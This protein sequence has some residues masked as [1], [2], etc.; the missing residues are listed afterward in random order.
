L[1][2][3]NYAGNPPSVALEVRIAELAQRTSI[4]SSG[5][6]MNEMLEFL[7]AMRQLRI[8]VEALEKE[9]E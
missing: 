7:Q 8:R 6:A 1:G 9:K 4:D 5:V 2:W 3:L